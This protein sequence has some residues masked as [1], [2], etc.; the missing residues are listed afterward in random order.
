MTDMS[1]SPHLE[2][3]EPPK[4]CPDCGAVKPATEFRRNRARPDGRAHYCTDCFRIRD[5]KDYKRRRLTAGKRYYG[6]VAVP[7]GFKFCRRCERVKS[8]DEWHRNRSSRDGLTVYCKECR[9]ELSRIDHL[10]RQ[11]GLASEEFETLLSEHPV[12]PICRQRKPQHV[13][14]DHDSGAVRGLLCQPCNM[15]LGLLGEDSA[16]LRRAASYLEGD[17]WRPIP[18]A[19]GVFQLPS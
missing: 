5:A 8:V 12:C 6:G 11:Y 15:G 17:V 13:D 1:G 2:G 9:A 16:R 3:S 14:R 4:R 19:A 7:D 18:L 10:R